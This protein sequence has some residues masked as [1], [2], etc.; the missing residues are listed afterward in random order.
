MPKQ[1][2]QEKRVQSLSWED[3]PG[4]RKQPPTP[5]FLTG[6]SHGQRGL[7]SYRPWGLKEA[8]ATK[9]LSTH[10]HMCVHHHLELCL[11]Q[12]ECFLRR[13]VVAVVITEAAMAPSK[14][15]ARETHTPLSDKYAS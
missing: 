10:A 11:A 3:S 6:E 14:K 12:T 4:V 7:G 1:E 8:D 5:V 15:I 13:L 2:T 9:G